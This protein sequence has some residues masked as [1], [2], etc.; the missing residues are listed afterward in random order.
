MKQLTDFIYEY[1][2]R[3]ISSSSDKQI[4]RVDGF[5]D[6]RIYRRLCERVNSLC[7]ERGWTLVAK[8][9]NNKFKQFVQMNQWPSEAEIMRQNGWVDE[10]DHMTSYRNMLPEN[11]KK[12]VV[13]LLGTDMVDDK[14]GLN[15]FFAITP[16]KIDAEIGNKYSKLI[17]Q[18]L[19]EAFDD[20]SICDV[21]DRFFSDLF[22]CVPKNVTAVSDILDHWL[23]ET[24]NVKEAMCEL[25][26]MLPDW[27]IP[28]IIDRIERLS[29]SKFI[30]M[31]NKKSL[32]IQASDFING[33]TY[34]KVT[35]STVANVEKKFSA[36][37]GDDG[38]EPGKYYMDYPVGQ[39][40]DSIDDLQRIA[41][42][43]IIGNRNTDYRNALI[44]TD[45]SILDEILNIKT[46]TPPPPS[47]RIKI[48]G[49]PIT[50]LLT[51]FM[52][53]IDDNPL[54]ADTVCI[55]WTQA[56][57]CGIP[58]NVEAG[59]AAE[60]DA[61]IAEEWNK[62]T[63]FS[64]GVI[65]F[66]N[67]EN[68]NGNDGSSIELTIEP[69]GFLNPQSS[70][71]LIN[72]G[73]VTTG[74][75]ST[76]KIDFT[77]ETLC[78]GTVIGNKEYCWCVDPG[79]DWVLAF[80]DFEGMPDEETSYIPFMTVPDINN[81]FALKDEDGFSYWITHSE[82]SPL[83]G[84]N[85]I[86]N[87]LQRELSAS[88]DDLESAKFYKLGSKFQDFRR[89]VIH[90]GFFSTVHSSAR[91]FLD[92]Y[93]NLAK[94]MTNEPI[95][96]GKLH[97][98][99]G[100]FAFFF[101]MCQDHSC[102]AGG[103]SAKQIIVPPWNPAT[104]EKIIDQ[105]QFI[106]AGMREWNEKRTD[107]RPHIDAAID[108]L[109][110][111]SSIHNSTDAFFGADGHPLT[112]NTSFGY[113]SLY[114]A[115]QNE[116]NFV[117]AQQI[118]RKEAVFA[119][120]FDDGDMKRMTREA[121]VLLHVIEQY[122]ET[123]P[124]A[125]RSLSITFINPDDLQIV[126][127]AL[128]K[129][130]A[131]LQK[132]DED[133]PISINLHVVTRNNTQG[134]R[135]Y[136]AYWINHVFTSDDNLDI[137]A[138]LLSYSNE[139]E[140][141]KLIAPTTD[142]AFFFDA[143]NTNQNAA[144]HFYKSA[145]FEKM[146]DCRYPM[147]FKPA[148]KA[149]Y[150]LQHA[151]DITQP[152]FR[153]ASAHTQ[154]LR[155][156]N[157]KQQYDYQSAFV[158]TSSADQDRGAIIKLVQDRV[159][160]LC[161]IDSAMDKY[162]VR[163]LYAQNTGIIGFTTGEGSYGQMNLAIT[164]RPDVASDMQRR[165]KRRLHRMFPSWDDAQLSVAADCCL[166]KAGELD[167]VSILRAMNPNDYDMNNFLAYL[168]ANAL[169]D[170]KKNK[171]SILIRL[172]SYRH[173]FGDAGASER[174]IPDFL[175]LESDVQSTTDSLHIKA[176]VIEAKI[177][178]GISMMTEHIP[179]AKQQVKNGIEVLMK[180]FDPNS[181]SV[182]RR[183]WLAQLYRAIAFLQAD[184]DFDDVLFGVLTEKLNEM[185]EGQFTI[186]WN[187]RILGCEIDNNSVID[188]QIIDCD[189]QDIEHWQVG[190]LAMQN[191]LL[192]KEITAQ[193]KFDG[194]ATSEE[195]QFMPASMDQNDDTI[196]LDDAVS[197]IDYSEHEQEKDI[198]NEQQSDNKPQTDQAS[199]KNEDSQ[200][201]VPKESIDE[202]ESN[203]TD[204][205]VLSG[206]LED[207]RVLIGQD[208]LKHEI[209]WEF[210]HSQ[211]AN[212]HLLITGGSGQGKTYAIQT[213]LFELARQNIS[214]VVFDY[215]D[216]FLPGKLEPQFENELNGKIV[217][218][219]AIVGQLPI[220]PFKRQPLNIPG[221]PEGM[222]EQSTNVAS[223]FSAIL[224]HVY[225]FGEQQASALYQ[226][227]KDGIDHYG[228]QMDF[229]KLRQLL[230]AIQGPY[231]KTVLSKMQQLFDMDLFDTSSSFDWSSIT[232]KDGKVT[233]IQLTSLDREIQTIITEML[234]WDAWY[235]L[236]KCGDKT[237]P[238]VV[239]L[240]E[241][242]NLSISDGSPAQKILQEGRKYGWSAWFATQFMKGALSS[243][244]ISRLQQA[245][246][247]LYF[248]PSAEETSSVASMLSDSNTSASE[249]NETLKQMLKG[250]CIVKGDRIRTNNTFGSAPAVLVKVSSFDERI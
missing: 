88:G 126:V 79:E 69:A 104:L 80:R 214:S 201:D 78:N 59:G 120:D 47:K 151:I 183:Y 14:G 50:V 83:V 63:A 248:K 185:I 158:Q 159:V 163:K 176:T 244:E 10:D 121:T 9:S 35:K 215:T 162:S 130:V 42:A 155:V 239:V 173:W 76:H 148:L 100:R 233:V 204:A 112:H 129:F 46:K 195:E 36:Y 86:M 89:Q 93:L 224:K 245:A 131:N 72:D 25:F 186:E 7:F 43:Y 189:G 157:D 53:A 181:M 119:D 238:F 229:K 113:Y 209:Y 64:G 66:I 75:G 243:D 95:Y 4:I 70:I 87:S 102:V 138:Y 114:G 110:S 71:S 17:G 156:F 118:E 24:P 193:A 105:M 133:N 29:P 109:L 236:V 145:T 223:R 27:G 220:N 81:A 180:H 90:D 116:G 41:T 240:D 85:G 194:D 128:Y 132:D 225:S 235:S 174:K 198:S 196:L 49:T 44:H 67:E 5:E 242:Q 101:A 217:Q 216:G 218:H 192:G 211:L 140:I 205:P 246:E 62:I 74:T 226:A 154:I 127:A 3:N 168:I 152:Q 184:A 107:N 48:T 84:K 199:D 92:E 37:K 234:M 125:Q 231:A 170:K 197:E 38:S 23:Q 108:R 115:I 142:L 241:A 206:K 22:S 232:E 200:D 178:G 247:T 11:G 136:L 82:V 219:Y 117:S 122:V 20:P 28:R 97:A 32:L 99:V 6:L 31:K 55:R 208:R 144:Y 65:D 210:G 146:S 1:I 61:L 179:K 68:W 164:C 212:R 19:L 39:A 111:L 94:R 137:K 77:V 91:A 73:I 135:T 8:L 12:L 106:R 165:C 21:V 26:S 123:Y 175:L 167:G 166:K 16:N 237:R 143:M 52:N 18:E 51:A 149:K 169:V 182:E 13:L 150:G 56:K 147:V 207:V 54:G 139:R 222:L 40:I 203:N 249:W 2:R 202:P 134:A 96:T 15:D 172:D 45:F 188:K 30:Q 34:A 227:C 60:R 103:C 190:Q 171:L 161:C 177:A 160:W 230:S 213:F 141:P 221:L 124:Q 33:K 58:S 153:V 187:G 228:D 191:I 57:L 98:V 250:Q